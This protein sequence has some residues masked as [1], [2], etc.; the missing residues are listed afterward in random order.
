MTHYMEKVKYSKYSVDLKN[1]YKIISHDE[2][3]EK[4]TGYNDEDIAKGL[5]QKMLIFDNEWQEYSNTIKKA[6]EDST[7]GCFDHRLRIKNGSS[8]SVICYGNVKNDIMEIF[9]ADITDTKLLKSEVN[10]MRDQILIQN[11]QMRMI[12]EGTEEKII[13]YHVGSD[14]C[15]IYSVV[16][17]DYIEIERIENADN[18]DSWKDKVYRSDINVFINNFNFIKETGKETSFECRL[19]IGNRSDYVWGNVNLYS[20]ADE[21]TGRSREIIGRIRSIHKEKLVNIELR[22]RA[23]RD[24]LTGLYNQVY[25]KKYIDRCLETDDDGECAFLMLDLDNFKNVNDTYGHY[26]GDKLIINIA[27][28]LSGICKNNAKICRM[29]GDE[30]AVFFNHCSADVVYNTVDR[31]CESIPN[32]NIDREMKIV[33]TGSLG[34]TFRKHEDDDFLT[35]YRRADKAMYDAKNSGKNKWVEI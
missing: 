24:Y 30:F 3:F 6:L 25:F 14:L 1:G 23:E 31:I 7:E 13:N 2:N 29:G 12:L 4:L 34:L 20:V 15:I 32:I 28:T 35:L 27:D 18:A 26:M 5:T 10:L 17:G 9:I 21:D 8:M 11:S 19:K 22:N 16:N 33:V